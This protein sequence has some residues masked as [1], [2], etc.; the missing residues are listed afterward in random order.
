MHEFSSKRQRMP[1]CDSFKSIA[2]LLMIQPIDMI[3]DR[4]ELKKKKKEQKN[5]GEFNFITLD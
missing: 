3:F 1:G 2:V 4:I 5:P